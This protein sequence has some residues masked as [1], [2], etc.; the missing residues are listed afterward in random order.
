MSTAPQI[1]P[2]ELCDADL[3]NLRRVY[4]RNNRGDPMMTADLDLD[5][6]GLAALLRVVR[7][8]GGFDWAAPD[9]H[10]TL[11][12]VCCMCWQPARFYGVTGGMEQGTRGTA[13]SAGWLLEGPEGLGRRTHHGGSTS[14]VHEQHEIAQGT[15][16]QCYAY[17]PSCPSPQEIEVGI[18]DEADLHARRT[19]VPWPHPLPLEVPLPSLQPLEPETHTLPQATSG[20]VLELT[21]D[22]GRVELLNPGGDLLATLEAGV[23]AVVRA[24][25][26]PP[27]DP[28]PDGHEPTFHW[29]LGRSSPEAP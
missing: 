11:Y 16:P 21:A 25:P 10:P 3:L 5:A 15:H 19:Q 27:P 26:D 1:A 18:T 20:A 8:G 7:H 12:A 23:V 22:A 14:R 9:P 13:R 2:D 24:V 4:G 29:A 28:L 6:A 17:C